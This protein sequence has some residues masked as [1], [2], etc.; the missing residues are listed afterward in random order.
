MSEA[1]L[2]PAAPAP[3]SLEERLTAWLDK[4]MQRSTCKAETASGLH[5]ATVPVVRSLGGLA[6]SSAAAM[7]ELRAKLR[8][9]ALKRLNNGHDLPALE[10]APV[11]VCAE[12]SGLFR[13]NRLRKLLLKRSGQ[14]GAVRT[15]LP[16][17]IIPPPLADFDALLTRHAMAIQSAS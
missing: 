10:A 17:G 1:F 3:Q 8:E 9:W 6:D 7:A 2:I 12:V 11:E 15:N 14:W 16:P 4:V 13:I 5:L